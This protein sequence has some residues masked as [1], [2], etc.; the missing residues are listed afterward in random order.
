MDSG[1]C[2]PWNT[3]MVEHTSTERRD[4]CLNNAAICEE[5][6]RVDPSNRRRWLQEAVRWRVFASENE[7]GGARSIVTEHE[8]VGGKLIPKLPKE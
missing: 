1:Q 4:I 3:D 8:L 2:E 6:A 7:R 5:Q